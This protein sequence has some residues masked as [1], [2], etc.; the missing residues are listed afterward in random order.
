[1][2]DTDIFLKRGKN[3]QICEDYIVADDPNTVI[4]SDGCTSSPM[5]DVGSRI[6]THSAFKCIAENQKRLSYNKDLWYQTT[7]EWIIHRAYAMAELMGL[8][9]FTLD[10]TLLMAYRVNDIINIHMYGDGYIILVSWDNKLTILEVSYEPNY[11]YYLSYLL[12]PLR[13]MSYGDKACIKRVTINGVKG[14]DNSYG[15]HSK[16]GYSLN[17]Y[18]TILI[19]SDGLGTF[20]F[21]DGRSDLDII[22]EIVTFKP[23]KVKNR[24][25]YRRAK[26]VISQYEKKG[27]THHDDIAIGGFR[28]RGTR[29]EILRQ[30]KEEEI[31]QV[32]SE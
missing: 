14:G 17:D 2:I 8:S 24:F 31:D 1:M 28:V 19:A 18:Q 15:V 25:I 6:L 20:N 27:F 29:D 13:K 32:G 22:N 3:H 21:S 4:I 11:P 12:D 7:G 5:T 26:K 16:Y 30:G 9:Q 23:S 10:A